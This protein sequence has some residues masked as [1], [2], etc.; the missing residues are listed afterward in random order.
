MSETGEMPPS[1][2][3][4]SPAAPGLGREGSKEGTGSR[5]GML[6]IPEDK[7]GLGS[8]VQQFLSSQTGHQRLQP[9]HSNPCPV[10][11]QPWLAQ[12]GP[13]PHPTETHQQAR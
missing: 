3:K 11:L 1:P 6:H 9:S 10:F 7:A 5:E 13:A 2:R 8:S 4:H 12:R